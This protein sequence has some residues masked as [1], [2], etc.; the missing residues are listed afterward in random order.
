MSPTFLTGKLTLSLLFLLGVTSCNFRVYTNGKYSHKEKGLTSHWHSD[1]DSCFVLP[2][3]DSLPHGADYV[4][5]TRLLTPFV[6]MTLKPIE[7][8]RDRAKDEARRQGANLIQI[9]DSDGSIMTRATWYMKFYRLEGLALAEYHRHLDSIAAVNSHYAVVHIWNYT[10]HWEDP[11]PCYF[12]DSLVGYCQ[13]PT[14]RKTGRGLKVHE[15]DL[16]FA[17]AGTLSLGVGAQSSRSVRPLE[18]GH[19]YDLFIMPGRYGNFFSTSATS[20]LSLPGALP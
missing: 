1:F 19:E 18:L 7:M 3:K 6:W 2:G 13:A 12:N 15:L 8:M 14:L 20:G 17:T 11:A 4:S 16:R 5:D 10:Y 9:T